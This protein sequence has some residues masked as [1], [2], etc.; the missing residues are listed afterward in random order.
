MQVVVEASDLLPD[1]SSA[2]DLPDLGKVMTAA[3]GTWSLTIPDPLPPAVEEAVSGNGGALNVTATT[4]GHTTSGVRLVGTD[5][6]TAAP[7]APDTGKP[8]P[9][10][11]SVGA[12]GAHTVQLMPLPSGAETTVPEPTAEQLKTTYANSVE[13]QPA[14]DPDAPTPLWQ[15]DR[16]PAPTDYNPY[17][18]NGTNISAEPVT[19]YIDVC[20][21]H[22]VVI[23]RQIAYTTVGESHAY[24]DAAG[25]ADYSSKLSSTFDLG[26]SVDG[27]NWKVGGSVSLGSSIA[28]TVGFTWRGPYFAKQLRVPI[29]YSKVKVVNDCYG[30]LQAHYEIRAGRYKIP[31]GGAVATYG[32]DARHLDGPT[33]FSQ[34]NPRYRAQLPPGFTFALK[35][36]KSVKW[37]GAATAFGYSVG[38][39]SSYD[40]EHGQYIRAGGKTTNKHDVWGLYAQIDANAGVIYSW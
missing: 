11:A 30:D 18:V 14:Y 17:V 36:G 34:S 2:V 29:E 10:A 1:D 38:G 22:S 37:A 26:Y 12:S 19:P 39:S 31:A 8:T 21:W 5:H 24:W 7:P 28:A 13:S 40:S 15:S 6:L 32:K 4:V 20:K 27:K 35:K 9:F 25:Y 33:R 23:A 3:D 16:G